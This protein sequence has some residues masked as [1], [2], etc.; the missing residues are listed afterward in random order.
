M[1][2]LCCINSLAVTALALIL[3]ACAHKPTSAL[4][5]NLPLGSKT[6]QLTPEDVPVLYTSPAGEQRCSSISAE[7]NKLDSG[8]GGAAVE[9]P[10]A[11]KPTAMDRATSF[12]KNLAIE[13]VKGVVQPV[14][15]TKRAIMNDE[16]NEK[17][18][19]EAAQRGNIRRAYLK[20][21]YEGLACGTQAPVEQNASAH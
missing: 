21:I 12:G 2:M 16:A 9:T 3:C 13:S 11:A 17:R 10:P 1:R 8:L 20:G 19:L 15:Q 18:A 14:I 7:I 5:Q 4:T 6:A